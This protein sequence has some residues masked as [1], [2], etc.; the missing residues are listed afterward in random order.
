MLRLYSDE[1]AQMPDKILYLDN[2]VICRR[3]PL[4]FYNQNMS[5]YDLQVYLIIMEVGFFIIIRRAVIILILG[6]YCLT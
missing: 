3:D 4:E 6:Y 1:I 2:D 5:E